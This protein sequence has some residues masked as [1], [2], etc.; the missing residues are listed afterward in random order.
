MPNRTTSVALV[1]GLASLL[2]D[3]L[4]IPELKQINEEWLLTIVAVVGAIS[5]WWASR[6]A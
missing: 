6:A 3:W 1:W 2:A 5:V 4:G